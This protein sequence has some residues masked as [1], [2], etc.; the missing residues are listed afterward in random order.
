ML[1]W[2]IHNIDQNSYQEINKRTELMRWRHPF[3]NWSIN[4]RFDRLTSITSQ[5]QQCIIRTFWVPKVFH[6]FTTY[7][8]K[9]NEFNF[10]THWCNVYRSRFHKVCFRSNGF[11]GIVQ[12]RHSSVHHSPLR[13]IHPVRMGVFTAFQTRLVCA[14]VTVLCCPS[15]STL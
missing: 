11:V 14:G 12:P 10:G 8:W 4:M 3:S 13:S 2:I 1:P 7:F 5:R 6:S 15:F 9:Q